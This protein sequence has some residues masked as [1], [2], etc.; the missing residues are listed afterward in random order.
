M[1]ILKNYYPFRTYVDNAQEDNPNEV[2]QVHLGG[3]DI[4]MPDVAEDLYQ[5]KK[6][7][8]IKVCVRYGYPVLFRYLLQVFFNN[9]FDYI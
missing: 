6:R 9:N 7:L 4:D 5:P 8:T 2:M 1:I 3:G